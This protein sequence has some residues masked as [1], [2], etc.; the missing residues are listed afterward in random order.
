MKESAKDRIASIEA[1][2]EELDNL[3]SD[4]TE[5]TFSFVFNN[6][7]KKADDGDS[8]AIRIIDA[9]KAFHKALKRGEAIEEMLQRSVKQP[10]LQQII[11][12][13]VNAMQHI[14]AASKS[15]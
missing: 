15:V 8:E 9:M 5:D 1:K 4:M 7:S 6:I 2:L 13:Y 12:N 14:V 11:M 10:E 3:S